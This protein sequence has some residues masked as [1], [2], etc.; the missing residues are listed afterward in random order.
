MVLTDDNLKHCCRC[1][2]SC[3]LEYFDVNKKGELYKTC[4]LCLTRDHKTKHDYYEANKEELNKT[5]K[6][7]QLNNREKPLKQKK[8]YY[9]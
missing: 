4:R 1:N 3:L 9:Q 5:N 6:E 7:W 8:K 2:H